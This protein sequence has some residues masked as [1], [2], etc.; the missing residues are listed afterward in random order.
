MNNRELFG[1]FSHNSQFF[2]ILF[3]VGIFL[4]SSSLMLHNLDQK[5][6]WIDEFNSIKIAEKTPDQIINICLTTEPHPPVQYLAL[7]YFQGMEKDSGVTA[8]R[9]MY[10]IFGILSVLFFYPMIRCVVDRN[11]ALLSTF[12]ISI[13]PFLIMY[14]RMARYYSLVL[15]LSIISFYLFFRI[16]NNKTS[17]K[18]IHYILLIIFLTLLL[19]TYIP[20]FAVILTQICYLGY[21]EW[22]NRAVGQQFNLFLIILKWKYLIIA[23]VGAGLLFLPWLIGMYIFQPAISAGSTAVIGGLVQFPLRFI[24]PFYVYSIGSTVYP[25]TWYGI[26]GLLIFLS[27]FLF[28]VYQFYK[29]KEFGLLILFIIPLLATNCILQLFNTSF[30]DLPQRAMFTL[31]FFIA[32]IGYAISKIKIN[33]FKIATICVIILVSGISISNYYSDK[34]FIDP[35]YIVPAK[36]IVSD[37]QKNLTSTDIIITQQS[38]AIGYYWTLNDNYPSTVPVYT[39]ILDTPDILEKINSTS[40]QGNNQ[41]SSRYILL[42]ENTD[43]HGEFTEEWALVIDDLVRHG[44]VLKEQKNYVPTDP[45]FKKFKELVLKRPTFDYR[46]EE[47]VFIKT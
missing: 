10:V 16:I 47:K 45:L 34:E 39:I 40:I 35:M 3:L 5:S 43:T 20:A 17:H 38:T 22:K 42:I 32:I 24:V 28:A 8:S 36:E 12:L 25:W 4:L 13:S 29:E 33:L 6:P 11:I 27:L 2:E 26:L 30:I 19:Y 18:R 7:H 31:P 1:V 23:W 15:F 14:S 21:T 9:M 37:L 44:Y 41:N 46:I